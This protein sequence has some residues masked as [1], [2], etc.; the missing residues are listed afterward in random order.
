MKAKVILEV[1]LEELVEIQQSYLEIR[2][3]PPGIEEIKTI[4]LIIF[5]QTEVIILKQIELKFIL[6]KGVYYE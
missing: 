5:S 3:E 2:E 1:T 6:Y 4:L